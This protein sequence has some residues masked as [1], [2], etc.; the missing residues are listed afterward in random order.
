M[1]NT[2]NTHQPNLE[3]TWCRHAVHDSI[4]KIKNNSF[5]KTKKAGTWIE[6]PQSISQ[7]ALWCLRWMLTT[8]N[9]SIPLK[10]EVLHVFR[11]STHTQTICKI[12]LQH[13]MLVEFSSRISLYHH[14]FVWFIC[15]LWSHA[16]SKPKQHLIGRLIFSDIQKQPGMW[17]HTWSQMMD[18]FSAFVHAQ[19]ANIRLREPIHAEHVHSKLA[20]VLSWG[21]PA[22]IR[23]DFFLMIKLGSTKPCGWMLFSLRPAVSNSKVKTHRGWFLFQ[24]LFRC[25]GRRKGYN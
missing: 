1:D 14:N 22:T 17:S 8:M 21:E 15:I 18:N 6:R 19:A 25:L 2:D 23:S 4:I 12:L 20:A 24:H 5:P 10:L 16:K 11:R 3:H 9:P 13:H 7:V